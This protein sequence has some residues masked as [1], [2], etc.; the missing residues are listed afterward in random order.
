MARPTNGPTGDALP[1]DIIEA[2]G[3]GLSEFGDD[4][5][6]DVVE[7]RADDDDGESWAP[8]P[9]EVAVALAISESRARLSVMLPSNSTRA[10]RTSISTPGIDILNDRSIEK[11]ARLPRTA[12]E[13]QI[14][15][16][17]RLSRVFAVPESEARAPE[18][19]T[20]SMSQLKN[21]GAKLGLLP[22]RALIASQPRVPAES[23]SR[24]TVEPSSRAPAE[25]SISRVATRLAVPKQGNEDGRLTADD[26]ITDEAR[27]W[28]ILLPS[29]PVLVV[30]N[31]I[32]TVLLLYICIVAPYFICFT[33]QPL[34][35]Y[36]AHYNLV[37]YRRLVYRLTTQC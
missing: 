3:P 37:G 24:V 36:I 30:W 13:G 6:D 22:S 14:L 10:L 33:T 17:A 11:L 8:D 2:L 4:E 34:E 9:P 25:P 26:F 21:A 29:A 23:P 19:L 27:Y 20:A 32:Q 18:L 5:G 35:G 7:S 28:F 31:I 15:R 12:D 16:G 1:L